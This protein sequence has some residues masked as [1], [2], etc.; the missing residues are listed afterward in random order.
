MVFAYSQDG[1][2]WTKFEHSFEVS[3]WHHN[4]LGGFL[5]LRLALWAQGEGTVTFNNFT[6]RPLDPDVI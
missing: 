5:A 4:A 1:E 2:E 3:G 6:Y